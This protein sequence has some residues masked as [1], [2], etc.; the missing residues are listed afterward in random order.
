MFRDAMIKSADLRISFPPG[1]S[2]HPHGSLLCTGFRASDTNVRA[3]DVMILHFRPK[4][5]EFQDFS[6]PQG[7]A[8][9]PDAELG[10][11]QLFR[12]FGADTFSKRVAACLIPVIRWV[13]TCTQVLPYY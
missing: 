11:F 4:N 12:G 6:D 9:R 10:E 3:G 8:G 2:N 7:G 5:R 13:L 1:A